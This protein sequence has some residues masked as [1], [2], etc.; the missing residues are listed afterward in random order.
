M[1]APTIAGLRALGHDVKLLDDWTAAV[2]GMQGITVDERFGTMQA[3][4]DPR[5]AGYAIGW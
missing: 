5:R 3:G 2:G 1:P 4:A